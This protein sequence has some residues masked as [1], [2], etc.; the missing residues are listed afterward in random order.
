M[1]ALYLHVLFSGAESAAD[2]RGVFDVLNIGQLLHMS[3]EQVTTRNNSTVC[4][5]LQTIMCINQR[6]FMQAKLAISKNGEALLKHA[7]ARRL[8]FIPLEVLPAEEVQKRYF[9][10]THSVLRVRTND[11]V[12]ALIDR[13]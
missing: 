9:K 3:Q 1:H 8:K 11:V 4:V 5:L 2:I 12:L 13:Y 10:C 7:K 6:C